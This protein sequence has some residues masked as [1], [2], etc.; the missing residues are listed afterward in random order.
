MGPGSVYEL[1]GLNQKGNSLVT[2]VMVTRATFPIVYQCLN[3]Q[4]WR[5][6][7]AADNGLCRLKTRDLTVM[8]VL[9]EIRLVS[10]SH[11]H[12]YPD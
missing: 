4:Y 10:I 1:Q 3:T 5:F 12:I 11:G 8:I 7:M 9:C 2:P 6:K